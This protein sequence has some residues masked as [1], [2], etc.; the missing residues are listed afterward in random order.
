MTGYVRFRARE[1]AAEKASRCASLKTLDLYE[2]R[3][4]IVHH[5]RC[6]LAGAET[7]RSPPNRSNGFTELTQGSA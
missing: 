7:P 3:D 2:T 1:P 4:Y 5:L 6:A